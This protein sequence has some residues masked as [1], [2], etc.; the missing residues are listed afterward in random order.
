MELRESADGLRW[1]IGRAGAMAVIWAQ[2]AKTASRVAGGIEPDVHLIKQVEQVTTPALEGP[3]WRFARIPS[4][5]GSRTP[6][7]PYIY[8][9]AIT[10]LAVIW[11]QKQPYRQKRAEGDLW[12]CCRP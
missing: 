8:D 1:E 12:Q 10:T 3:T 5:G 9:L 7:N 4:L 11:L 6:S 2:I